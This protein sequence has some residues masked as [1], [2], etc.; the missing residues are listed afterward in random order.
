MNS[1]DS[2]VN[3]RQF[4]EDHGELKETLYDL[5][6]KNK[7]NGFIINSGGIDYIMKK[8]DT[9]SDNDINLLIKQNAYIALKYGEKHTELVNNIQQLFRFEKDNTI[10][11]R[12]GWSDW[13]EFID[14]FDGKIQGSV[15]DILEGNPSWIYDNSN[16]SYEDEYWNWLDADS[17]VL[18]RKYI[19][20]KFNHDVHTMADA[21]EYLENLED[22]EDEEYFHD[23]LTRS[24][25][26]A[27]SSA[28]EREYFEK[29]IDSLLDIVAIKNKFQYD[30]EKNEYTFP[31]YSVENI[32]HILNS[33]QQNDENNNEYPGTQSSNFFAFW[34]YALKDQGELAKPNFDN[35]YGDATIKKDGEQFNYRFQTEFEIPEMPET[36]QLELDL[37]GI[38]RGMT[39]FD[40]FIKKLF[41]EGLG[42][43]G[44]NGLANRG[45]SGTQAASPTS[46]TAVPQS[47]VSNGVKMPFSGS[48]GVKPMNPSAMQNNNTIDYGS[49]FSS[50]DPNTMKLFMSDPN[51]IEVFK[52]HMSDDKN[53][54]ALTSSIKDPN[55]WKTIMDLMRTPSPQ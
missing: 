28:L 44:K 52:Q 3:L 41:E 42:D 9:F 43:M 38:N 55:Q 10:T 46:S 45:G 54:Q 39:Q 24:Y 29:T 4:F 30:N 16:N 13:T 6:L 32:E 23:I 49:I 47:K 48:T 5:A 33:F 11:L 34:N 12:S 35:I 37:S 21:A 51:N 17:Q 31:G 14:F 36:T 1:D 18:I 40:Q 2:G 25:D 27:Y 8:M 7:N 53:Y 20:N 19:K 22:N 50:K 15:T 26:D